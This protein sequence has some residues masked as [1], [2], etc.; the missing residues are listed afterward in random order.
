M[1][2]IADGGSTKTDWRLIKDGKETRQFLTS[3]FNPFQ[4]DANEIEAILWKDLQ[5]FLD[6]QGVNSIFY[7]GTGCSTMQKCLIVENAFE[8]VFPN[9]RIN[10]HHDLMAAAHALCGNKPGIATI[11]G[12]GSNSCHY[13]GRA[14]V[15][16][17]FSLGYLLGDE[18]SGAYLGK[19]LLD[20]YL[21]KQLPADLNSSFEEAFPYGRESMLERIYAKNAPAKFLASFNPWLLTCKGHPFVDGLL[22][23]AFRKFFEVQV[24]CYASY[25][26]LPVHFSGSVAFVYRPLIEEV[27]REYGITT[28]KFIQSPI[29]DLVKFYC[30]HN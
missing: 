5:P 8:K 22:R 9:A 23:D 15:E 26:E 13:N 4:T 14:I 2:L 16:R 20:K 11:L 7:Y 27:A 6:N 19:Q 3:G 29:D 24:C 25:R 28:G 17:I 10:I 18:G 12:T 1:I 30:G 21:R